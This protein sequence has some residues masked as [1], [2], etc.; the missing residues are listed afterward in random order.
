MISHRVE[1]NQ[2]SDLIEVLAPFTR[3]TRDRF[4][5]AGARWRQSRH[6]WMRFQSHLWLRAVSKVARMFSLAAGAMP[7]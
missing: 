6:H 5:R 1:E 2:L 7:R 3:S 4:S